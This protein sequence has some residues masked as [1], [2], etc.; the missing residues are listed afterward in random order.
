LNHRSN[1]RLFLRTSASALFACSALAFSSQAF[2][3][4]AP[5]APG[6]APAT[7]PVALPVPFPASL[8][9]SKGNGTFTAAQTAALND[10]VKKALETI[11][12]SSSSGQVKTTRETF[13]NA[14]MIGPGQPAAPAYER[15]F[16]TAV[17][18]EG[19]VQ[20]K[21]PDVRGRTAVAVAINRVVIRT[22]NAGLTPVIRAMLA[23]KSEAV[24]T[25]GVRSARTLYLPLLAAS[26][27]DAAALAQGMLAAMRAYPTSVGI[28][29]DTFEG[30]AGKDVQAQALVTAGVGN[31]QAIDTMTLLLETRAQTF[32]GATPGLLPENDPKFPAIIP[33]AKNDT[34]PEARLL[35]FMVGG[36]V[37]KVLA[38][39]PKQ[40]AALCRAM[41]D[42]CD[43]MIRLAPLLPPAAA[44]NAPEIRR[45]D[46]AQILLF[47]SSSLS[48]ATSD[49]PA[50]AAPTRGLRDLAREANDQ[51]GMQGKLQ[52]IE[53]ELTANN[54]MAPKPA[55]P[56]PAP[57]SPA[58]TTPKPAVA[59]VKTGG[60][61]GAGTPTGSGAAKP[62]GAGKA[63]A[64]N[65]SLN[66]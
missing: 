43:Q 52:E 55:A 32:E 49:T 8:M 16:V 60:A 48:V 64:G 28:V 1:H 42:L 61:T 45:G 34:G 17:S 63:A 37:K 27:K 46:L 14:A 15:A 21:K 58:P 47:A 9:V 40:R 20:M 51:A 53:K 26:P 57:V 44:A 3:Q 50:L 11:A 56:A 66:K 5:V 24:A 54:L 30:L 36:D 7:A 4:A 10:Y 12:T 62:A 25:W 59:P 2:G 13:E 18:N 29:E 33:A 31:M 38:N 23:D 19:L 6:A 35:T 41:Y 22:R 39:A 65:S